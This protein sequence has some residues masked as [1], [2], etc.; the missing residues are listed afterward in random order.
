MLTVISDSENMLISKKNMH[1][2]NGEMVETSKDHLELQK[3]VIS[4]KK[5]YCQFSN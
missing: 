5:N 3:D 2:F 1:A 4:W